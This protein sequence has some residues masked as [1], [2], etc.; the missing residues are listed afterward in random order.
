MMG[1]SD[2]HLCKTGFL[3]FK[4]NAVATGNRS[5]CLPGSRGP[6]SLLRSGDKA[7]PEIAL[8]SHG[9][10]CSCSA[11]AWSRKALTVWYFSTTAHAFTFEQTSCPFPARLTSTS[12]LEKK[13]P[14]KVPGRLGAG[15]CCVMVPAVG[16]GARLMGWG[17]CVLSRFSPTVCNPMD[18][19]HQVALSLGFSTQ[20]YRSGLP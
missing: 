15:V 16:E 4:A 3:G 10:T 1:L 7:L 18:V 8:F 12:T 19:A 13:S 9:L 20:E 11:S 17:L 14:C 5:G 2:F 6:P